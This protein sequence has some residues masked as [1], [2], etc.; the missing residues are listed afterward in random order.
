[1]SAINDLTEERLRALAEVRDEQQSVLSLYLDLDPSRFSTTGARAQEI[2]SLLDRASREIEQ[3]S[4]TNGQR[5]HLRQALERAERILASDD[6][7]AKGARSIALFTSEPLELSQLL[8][9]PAPL[10]SEVV[11]DDSP[12]ILPL[13]EAGPAG[14]VCV[15]LLDERFARILRGSGEHL[16]EIISFGDDV[17]GRHDQGGW[18]QARYQRSREHDVDAHLRRAAKLLHDLLRVSPYE[19]LVLACAEPLW[20][21]ALHEL[22]P[23]VKAVLHRSRLSLEVRTASL[24]DVSRAAA[25]V[26]AQEREAQI[27]TALA[28]FKELY[29]R[30]Q[31]RRAVGGLADVLEALAQR[32]VQT[33]LYDASARL[34]GLRCPSCGWLGHEKARESC[35]IDGSKLEVRADILAD[36][37]QAAITQ[38]AAVLAL[39]GRPDLGPLGGIGATLRF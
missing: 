33:L 26:L 39:R 11:I 23:D 7:W 1:M 36:A 32:R 20:S 27:E 24:E 15:A 10:R 31:D 8:R 35:P 12:F 13:L 18:S 5:R 34:Q 25:D 9:L 4:R 30:E 6:G 21:R 38:G 16:S 2:S 37:A 17:P 29:G 19:R 3:P 28:R 14:S 22:H